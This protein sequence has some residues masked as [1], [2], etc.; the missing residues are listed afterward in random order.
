MLTGCVVEMHHGRVKRH[1]ST[2]ALLG[3]MPKCSAPIEGGLMEET[4]VSGFVSSADAD[5][6]ILTV[7]V[8]QGVESSPISTY[9]VGQKVSVSLFEHDG[10]T[11]KSMLN[12]ESTENQS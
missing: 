12:P 3:K 8:N 4:T 2:A 11:D 7:Q 5:S 1:G 10:L 9:L 6:Q